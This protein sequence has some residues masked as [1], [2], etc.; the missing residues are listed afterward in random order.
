VVLDVSQQAAAFKDDRD[1]EPSSAHRWTIDFAGSAPRFTDQ[2]V[3]DVLMDLPA[4][5]RRL[6]GRRHR[7]AWYAGIEQ[8]GEYGFDMAGVNRLDQDT[9]ALDRWDPGS[10]YRAGEVVFVPAAEKAAE[11]EGWLLCFAY[12]R[13]RDTSDFIVLDATDVAAGPV[14]RI[15]LPSR[16][17]YGFHGWWIAD[18]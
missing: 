5:D 12:D 6:V 11:G 10:L 17:P 1:L 9:G 13:S 7:Y 16:V 18:D 2:L 3:A 15:K 14:A 4:V 8:Q